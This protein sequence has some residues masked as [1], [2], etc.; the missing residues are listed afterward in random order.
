MKSVLY[1]ALGGAVGAVSRYGINQLLKPASA[2]VF[3]IHTFAI[4]VSGCFLIGIAAAFLLRQTEGDLLR[5]FVIAGVLGG[6]TTFSSFS[7]ETIQLLQQQRLLL[8][9]WYVSLSNILGIAATFGGYHI[10]KNFT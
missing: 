3:P 10:V 2:G 1:I 9:I 5:Y 8:A 4:N 6:Y 7:L